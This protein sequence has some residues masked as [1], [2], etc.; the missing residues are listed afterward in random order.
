MAKKSKSQTHVIIF[1]LLLLLVKSASFNVEDSCKQFFRVCDPRWNEDVLFTGFILDSYN[2]FTVYL[3]LFLIL[4]F[5]NIP[6]LSL[7][8]LN[9][10]CLN[11]A[12]QQLVL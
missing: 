8:Q 2:L 7:S 6:T 5:L 3:L 11:R 1:K 4:F 12:L 10:S 9:R